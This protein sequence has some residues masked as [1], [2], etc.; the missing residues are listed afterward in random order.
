MPQEWL[1]TLTLQ[2]DLSVE[3]LVLAGLTFSNTQLALRGENG[4]HRLTSFESGFYEGEL[5]ATGQLDATGN[6]LEWQLSPNVRNVQVAPLIETSPSN[7]TPPSI[8][9]RST[10]EAPS[11]LSR[12]AGLP[13][14]GLFRLGHVSLPT[15]HTNPS[16]EENP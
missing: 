4:S 1:R 6:V 7:G 16:P 13:P 5:N 9:I 10:T 8:T 3:Q 14:P 12:F 15:G 2:G 11:K